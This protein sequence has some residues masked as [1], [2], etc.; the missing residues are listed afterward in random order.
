MEQSLR[1][2]MTQVMTG[3]GSFTRRVPHALYWNVFLDNTTPIVWLLLIAFATRARRRRSPE[4]LAETLLSAFPFVFALMLSFSPK[5]N[6]RYFLPATA[7]LTL[8]AALGVLSVPALAVRVLGFFGMQRAERLFS[9]EVRLG[10]AWALGALL[11]VLQLTG[12]TPGKPGLIRYD[13]AFREDDI[14]DLAAWLRHNV[15]ADAVIVADHRAGLQN[16]ARKRQLAPANQVPQQLRVSKL[17]SDEGSLEEL[18]SQGVG[19]V[20]VSETS[21]GKFFREDLRAQDARDRAY[22]KAKT[23]YAELLREG[24]LLLR[25]GPRDGDLFASGDPGVSA[26]AARSPHT[27]LGRATPVWGVGGREHARAADDVAQRRG[28]SP[29][30]VRCS[31]STRK[32]SRGSSNTRRNMLPGR[33][34]GKTEHHRSFESRAV[35]PDGVSVAVQDWAG[36]AGPGTRQDVLLLHGFSQCHKAWL[37]QFAGSLR[38]GFSAGLRPAR[39]RRL[40]QADGCQPLPGIEDS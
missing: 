24:G 40:R 28:Y 29:S 38:A 16:P 23:F 18:R 36:P 19:Y 37:Q 4:R 39:P 33:I 15:P 17:A 30:R 31:I 21:Y 35:A 3:Q 34:A 14:A 27:E 8:L 26:R 20:V 6:D 7:M 9:R 11:C 25:A 13:E 12:W 5:E 10:T 2:E 1:N 22:L 32:S